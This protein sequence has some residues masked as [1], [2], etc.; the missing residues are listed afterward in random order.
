LK[1]NIE[2]DLEEV[3]WVGMDWIDLAQDRDRWQALLNAVMNLWVRKN[4]G[5]FLISS[6]PLSFSKRTLL[7]T[8]M[9]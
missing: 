1:D 8:L 2:M 4:V 3:G 5:N 9:K 7:H 6:G